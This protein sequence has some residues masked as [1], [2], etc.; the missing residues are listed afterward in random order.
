MEQFQ[1]RKKAEDL[2][3]ISQVDKDGFGTSPVPESY[4]KAVIEN[5][6]MKD[7]YYELHSL[8]IT[9]GTY[10]AMNFNTYVV[11]LKPNVQQYEYFG[12]T[13]SNSKS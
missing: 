4:L 7:E 10:I 8:S 1:L 11:K 3:F 6:L 9:N 12:K 2:I 13:K 5:S